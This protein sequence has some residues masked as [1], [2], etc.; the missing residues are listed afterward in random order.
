MKKFIKTI[1]TIVLILAASI[2]CYLAYVFLTYS[3]IEDHLALTPEGTPSAETLSTGVTYTAV[4]QNCGFGAYTP[5]FTFFMDGGTQSWADSR[6]S[7]IDCIRNA[8][9]TAL[10][11]EPDFVL[12]QEVDTDSTR[13]YHVDQRELLKELFQGYADVFAVNYHSAFL[14]YPLYQPHGASNSGLLTFSKAAISDAERRSLEVSDGFS[15]FLDLDRCYSVSHIPVDN[16]REL[17]LYN[18]HSSAYG[19]S[20]RIRTSQMTQ[21]FSDMAAQYEA[22]NY[23]VCG[24][25]FNHDFTGDSIGY[26]G[27]SAVDSGWAQPFPTELLPEGLDRAIDY[28]DDPLVPSNRICSVPY[29]P[30]CLVCILDGFVVSDNVSVEELHNVDVGFS[31]SDHQPVV[32]RFSLK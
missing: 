5:D 15:R 17:V 1:F 3:R 16:G 23:C 4:S 6:D 31:F 10:S 18:I 9:E 2:L 12:Y 26:F 20:P 30:D 25:D 21:L 27:F 13:S 14:M 24:G 19:G 11:Y 8:G 29:G 7:V 32:I 28:N 22:G